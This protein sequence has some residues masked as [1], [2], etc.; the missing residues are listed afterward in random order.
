MF[1]PLLQIKYVLTCGRR[2]K[3]FEERDDIPYDSAHKTIA[4]AEV[5]GPVHCILTCTVEVRQYV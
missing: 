2:K 1:Y 5:G 3:L 4:E